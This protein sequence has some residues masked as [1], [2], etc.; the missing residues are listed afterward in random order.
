M[1]T[2]KNTRTGKTVSVPDHYIGHPVLG[3]NL[4]VVNDEV[5]AAPKKENK[6]KAETK[7]FSWMESA[8]ETEEQPAPET[9]IENEEIEDGN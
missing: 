3:K 4:I 1:A 7:G 2:A 5:E 9:T 8:K 6:K